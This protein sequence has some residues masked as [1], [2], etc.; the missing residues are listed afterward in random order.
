MDEEKLS[1]D[2]QVSHLQY[3]LPQ[4]KT[5]YDWAILSQYS[6]YF[7]LEYPINIRKDKIS[8]KLSLHAE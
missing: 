3:F 6:N 2:L 5:S 8:V 4:E 7:F 1:V